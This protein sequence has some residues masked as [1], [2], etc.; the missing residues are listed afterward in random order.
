[1][2][3][4]ILTL[5]KQHEKGIELQ[6]VMNPIFFIL[7]HQGIFQSMLVPEEYIQSIIAAD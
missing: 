2:H 3:K 1:M 7:F 6:L 5:P 4:I